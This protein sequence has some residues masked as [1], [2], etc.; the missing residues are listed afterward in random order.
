[1]LKSLPTPPAHSRWEILEKISPDLPKRQ[2]ERSFRVRC[3]C[4]SEIERVLAYRYVR[5]E[6]LSCGCLVREG[7][8]EIGRANLDI[9]NFGYREWLK[10]H[11]KKSSKFAPKLPS[12]EMVTLRD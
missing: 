11:P 8:A 10:T 4:G 2:S 6:S 9:M 3:T 5:G 7:A 1:M 12:L